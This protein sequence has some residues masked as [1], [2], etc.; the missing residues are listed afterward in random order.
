[1]LLGILPGVSNDYV[2]GALGV[3]YS[4]AVELRDR[5]DELHQGYYFCLPENQIA[6]TAMENLGGLI[7]LMQE[8]KIYSNIPVTDSDTAGQYDVIKQTSTGSNIGIFQWHV[9]IM[10]FL[11]MFQLSTVSI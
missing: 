6:D 11:Y 8:S 4:F 5:S 3:K 10:A 2:Y 7:T 9:Y 1:M